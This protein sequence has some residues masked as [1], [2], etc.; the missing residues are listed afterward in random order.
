MQISTIGWCHSIWHIKYWFEV[1]KWKKSKFAN[2]E[3]RPLRS[4]F[5][6]FLLSSSY[7]VTVL[8][9]AIAIRI[10]N[11][12]EWTWLPAFIIQLP[13]RGTAIS[14]SISIAIQFWYSKSYIIYIK[15]G[16]NSHVEIHILCTLIYRCNGMKCRHEYNFK[17]ICCSLYICWRSI[18]FIWSDTDIFDIEHL[19]CIENFPWVKFIHWIYIIMKCVSN[20]TIMNQNSQPNHTV[21]VV[22]KIVWYI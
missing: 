9:L 13:C 4:R 3:I 18:K 20:T 17:W 10:Q 7:L 22:T 14:F 21:D 1:D 5:R 12:F 6:E 16:L 2:V 15:C 8:R 11:V 19:N